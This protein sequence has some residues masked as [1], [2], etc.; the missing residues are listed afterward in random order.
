MCVYTRDR[1]KAELLHKSKVL[2]ARAEVRHQK[3]QVVAGNDRTQPHTPPN[4]GGGLG[5]APR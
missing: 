5:T 2:L 4:N 1:R 3:N